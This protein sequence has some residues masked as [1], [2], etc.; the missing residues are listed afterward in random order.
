LSASSQP[1]LLPAIMRAHVYMVATLI[2]LLVNLLGVSGLIRVMT[3]P[4]WLRP[5]S[6]FSIQQILQ[7]VERR[8]RNPRNMRRRVCLRRSLTLY[9]FLMLSGRRPTIEFGVF[10]PASAEAKLQGHCWVSLEGLPI[11]EDSALPQAVVH[12]Q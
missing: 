8:L 7:V 1:G 5:Y 9:H 4:A 10:A 11:A 6:H 2:P 3:P 12:R